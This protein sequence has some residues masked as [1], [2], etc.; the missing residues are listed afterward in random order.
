MTDMISVIVTTY[1]WADALE[2]CLNSLLAQSDQHFEIIIADDGSSDA[3]LQ[4]I[5][6]FIA[7]T[8]ISLR[9]VYHE[10]M[11]FRAGTIRNKAVSI[12]NGK[13]L[14]FLD[15]DCVA[16][17]HFIS[18][19]RLLAETDYFVPGNR[20][21][22]SPSYTQNILQQKIKLHTKKI[23]FFVAQWIKGNINRILPLLHI[24]HNDW[25]Y[26]QSTQWQKAMTCNL[27]IWKQDFLAVNGF[28]ELFEGWGYE[29][30]DLVIRLI[31]Q[32]I[33]RKEG[34]FAIPVLHLWHP[35]NDRSQHDENYRR[36]LDRLTDK[37]MIIA[38]KGVDQYL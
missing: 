37:D 38:Q 26:R 13:Y 35:Q 11:G 21:L 10:D 4:K 9:H 30:S 23:G 18:R 32:G 24:R 5:N 15:G 1:N 28:D 2:A 19:H 29:D 16:F 31:H 8:T 34:R 12:S 33:R 27:G 25:R 36:L 6:K 20:I 3:T 22:L 14:L 17:P 7:N